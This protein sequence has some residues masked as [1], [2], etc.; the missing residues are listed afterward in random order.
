VSGLTNISGSSLLKEIDSGPAWLTGQTYG[1]EGSIACTV[2]LILSTITI[3]AL[4]NMKAE[5]D[6]GDLDL[7]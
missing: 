2:A 3:I 6:L 1:I 7:K 4:P 5:R